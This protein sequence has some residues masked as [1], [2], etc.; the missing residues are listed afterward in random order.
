MHPPPAPRPPT[1]PSFV[2]TERNGNSGKT[3]VWVLASSGT[4]GPGAWGG[5]GPHPCTRHTGKE[6]QGLPGP[7]S[8]PVRA[9]A[10]GWTFRSL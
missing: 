4:C 8:L 6:A 2:I 1:P 10:S 5:A 3:R 9:E 7:P